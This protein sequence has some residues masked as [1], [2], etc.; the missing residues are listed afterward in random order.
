MY[1]SIIVVIVIRSVSDSVKPLF[2]TSIQR[3]TISKSARRKPVPAVPLSCSTR[4][5][6]G[7][8]N[9]PVYVSGGW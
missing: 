2:S 8:R 1:L 5:S 7:E 6:F 3:L 4:G 9:L